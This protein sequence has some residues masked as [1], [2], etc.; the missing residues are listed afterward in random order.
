MYRE[1]GS[2]PNKIS[3]RPERDSCLFGAVSGDS[4]ALRRGAGRGSDYRL[5]AMPFALFA[6]K[7]HRR[8]IGAAAEIA[9]PLFLPP[10]ARIRI[11]PRHVIHF[12]SPRIPNGGIANKKTIL[13]GWSS[14]LCLHGML[15]TM[16]PL[17]VRGCICRRRPEE[18]VVPSPQKT[19]DPQQYFHREA[20]KNE[21]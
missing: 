19:K 15:D 17:R 6:V 8:K 18:Q 2:A 1:N 10:A 14:Y 9:A 3:S 20:P 12:R 11:F 5:A 16:H 13:T 7:A 4:P 21:K